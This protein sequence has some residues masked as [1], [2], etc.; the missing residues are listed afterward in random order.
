MLSNTLRLHELASFCDRHDITKG[1]L[2]SQI[3]SYLTKGEW[4]LFAKDLVFKALEQNTRDQ[5][6]KESIDERMGNNDAA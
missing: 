5:I 4:E 2:L 1:I 3:Q 6:E